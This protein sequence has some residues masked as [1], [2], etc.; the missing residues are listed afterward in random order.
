MDMLTWQLDF[1]FL[2]PFNNILNLL[3]F[4]LLL[5]LFVVGVLERQAFQK[6]T[7]RLMAF[8]VCVAI[9]LDLIIVLSHYAGAY[10]S[11][12]NARYY[13]P[14]S[15]ACALVPLFWLET[16]SE[17]TR[18]ALSTPLLLGSI[19]LFA[20]YHP[21]AV[22]GRFINQ[23]GPNLEIYFAHDYLEKTYPDK[24]VLVI[25][26]WPTEYT[27]L[28]YGAMSF[29]TANAAVPRVLAGLERHL[30]HDIIVVQQ[31][32]FATQAPVPEEA[33][34]PAY[35]LETVSEYETAEDRYIRI[36]KVR[37]GS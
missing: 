13:L 8:M 17:E 19:A 7:Q 33:L 2:L 32:P 36:S 34:S 27:A 12:T 35:A 25:A 20:L 9:G 3:S 14:F 6:P 29:Y 24:N 28:E 15:V 5:Y 22:E 10:A 18:S 37:L 11:H 1:R 31:I 21:I 30:Y 23:L 26:E 4:A 16:V